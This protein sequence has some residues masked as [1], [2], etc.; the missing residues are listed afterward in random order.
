[1]NASPIIYCADVIARLG[2]PSGPLVLV[3]RLSSGKGLAFPGGKKEKGEHLSDTA[4]RELLE[5]TGLTLSIEGVLGT[6]AADGRDERGRYVSTVFLGIAH[7]T[8]RDEPGKTRVLLLTIEEA[9]ARAGDFAFDHGDLL[10]DYL[11]FT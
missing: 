7:G 10:A 4:R 11:Y 8:P 5:E 9:L 6:Y 2:S 1:M 3:E